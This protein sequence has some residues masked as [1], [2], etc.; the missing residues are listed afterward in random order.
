MTY[1]TH[2]LDLLFQDTEHA[3]ASYLIQHEEGGILIESGPGSTQDTLQEKLAEHGL[4]TKDISDVLLT[5]IHL[6]HA[7]AAGWL[8]A[9]GAQIHVHHVG[10]PHMIDPEK[11]LSSAER[12][13]GDQMNQL[14]GEFLPVPEQKIHI[15]HDRDVIQVGDLSF[16]ALD[17]PGHAYHH[18]AY[19]FEDVC[20]SGDIGGVRIPTPGPKHLRVPM[21]PPGLHLEKWKESIR[22]LEERQFSKIA[23]THFGMYSDIAWHLDAVREGIKEAEAWMHKTMP[24]DLPIERLREEFIAWAEERSLE[25]GLKESW[26]DAF[27]EAN[28]SGMSADGLLR[29]WRKHIK[30]E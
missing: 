20:F 1:E 19:L 9:Q 5:H 30:S 16:L 8:A 15:L 3:I 17:T 12:I 6:D 13:Y 26:L 7:G 10:A 2:T 4:K 18:M 29:Y 14:W 25:R 11:L 22:R 23:P 24:K 28:P 21:P 27:E